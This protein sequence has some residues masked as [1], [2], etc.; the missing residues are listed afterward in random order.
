MGVKIKD[1]I[2]VEVFDDLLIPVS[3]GTDRAT[4]MRLGDFH[5][6]VKSEN[7]SAISAAVR[8]E[9]SN[10]KASSVASIDAVESA[11]GKSV[12]LTLKTPND[13]PIASV[14][15]PNVDAAELITLDEYKA[16]ANKRFQYYFVA[17][18]EKEKEKMQCY[19]I[20][21]ANQLMGQF[22]VSSAVSKFPVKFPFK[23]A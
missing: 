14:V 18:N 17:R 9:E 3:D 19:R 11:D 16:I 4:A 12:T 13:T 5:D 1:A 21:L 10:R 2:Q 23:F 15:L 6:A 22:S 8:E 20:Y 7:Q